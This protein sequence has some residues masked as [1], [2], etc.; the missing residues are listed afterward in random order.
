MEPLDRLMKRSHRMGSAS[1]EVEMSGGTGTLNLLAPV[2]LL[3]GATPDEHIGYVIVIENATE[4]LRAQKQSAWKEVARRVA[5]EIKN[6][7]TPISLS[8]EQIE[9]HVHRL[10]AALPMDGVRHPLPRCDRALQSRDLRVGREHAQP[11]RS[12]RIARSV[13]DRDAA[14]SR[15]EHDRRQLAGALCRSTQ[16][17]STDA[18]NGS[19]LPLVLADPEAMKRALG[20]LIDN[21]VEAMGQSLLRELRVTT[22]AADSGM[23]ELCV[24]DYGAG[25]YR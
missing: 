11:G 13:S 14:S 7:L 17:D 21:A 9:R 6:P 19:D 4:L 23:V 25:A 22:H 1:S 3:E 20:N 8:A 18:Q 24:S 16:G 15:P 5:H 12:V 10:D 2:A